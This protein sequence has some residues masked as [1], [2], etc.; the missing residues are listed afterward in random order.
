MGVRFSEDWI[1]LQFHPEADPQ[2]IAAYFKADEKRASVIEVHGEEK[3]EAILDGLNDERKIPLTY[4]TIIQN[5]L[6]YQL[7]SLR[8]R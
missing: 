7:I 5:S 4:E 6:K 3:Y 8:D 2:G 1:G